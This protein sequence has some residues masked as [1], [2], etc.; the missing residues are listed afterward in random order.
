[1]SGLSSSTGKRERDTPELT[2]HRIKSL[3]SFNTF[4]GFYPT[5]LGGHFTQAIL[6]QHWLPTVANMLRLIRKDTNRGRSGFLD[7]KNDRANSAYAA[8]DTRLETIEDWESR[9]IS[10]L[11]IFVPMS[12]L[13]LG[14]G[15]RAC[16]EGEDV[17][18]DLLGRVSRDKYCP[19][20]PYSLSLTDLLSRCI[21]TL[22]GR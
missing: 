9:D 18:E 16:G 22:Y 8:L 5:Q 10:T 12:T 14:L 13:E 21:V 3:G 2:M 15:I 7:E 20:R 1:M 6:V 19:P 17:K 4:P 11:H